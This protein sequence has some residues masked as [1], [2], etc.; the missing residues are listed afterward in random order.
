MKYELMVYTGVHEFNKDAERRYKDI[1]ALY[2]ARV[3]NAPTHAHW[4]VSFI[5]HG[6][7]GEVRVLWGIVTHP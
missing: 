3:Q 1:T 5:D 4:Q 6:P 7:A 2:R